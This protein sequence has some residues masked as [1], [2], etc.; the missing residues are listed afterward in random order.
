M[1]DL[2]FSPNFVGNE[3]KQ[4]LDSNPGESMDDCICIV[5]LC[6]GGTLNIHQAASPLVRLV[7]EE[8]SWEAS[9]HL[10]IFSLKIGV[11]PSQIVLPFA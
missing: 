9:D 3:G 4:G 5:P 7:E 8:K 6:L 1:Y 10:Q 11:E 2:Y